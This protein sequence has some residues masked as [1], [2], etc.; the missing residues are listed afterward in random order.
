MSNGKN[1][2]AEKW[3]IVRER[4]SKNSSWW[5][6][7]TQSRKTAIVENKMNVFIQNGRWSEPRGATRHIPCE[8]QRAT[9]LL[10]HVHR[11]QLRARRQSTWWTSVK[12]VVGKSQ[13]FLLASNTLGYVNWNCE[14]SDDCDV[15]S[16]SAMSS[17]HEMSFTHQCW[18]CFIFSRKPAE[19]YHTEIGESIFSSWLDGVHDNNQFQVGDF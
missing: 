1:G 11:T 16:S 7:S 19:S 2:S 13:T 4:A 15:S 3:K 9:I 5:S 17:E 18:P 8:I 12:S 6:I 14:T 10:Q